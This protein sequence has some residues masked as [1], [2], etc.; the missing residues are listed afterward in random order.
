MIRFFIYA[1]LA[2]FVGLALAGI[3]KDDPGYL[4]ISY[5]A[6]SLETSLAFVLAVLLVLAALVYCLLWVLAR[7]NPLRLLK[8]G[9]GHLL[10]RS[11]RA[12]SLSDKGLLLLTLGEWQQAYALLVE[13]A[14]RV[15]TP[16]INFL[17]ASLA[18]FENGDQHSCR[19]CL[20]QAE[21]NASGFDTNIQSWRARL[22][23]RAGR[24]EQS[25]S[26]LLEL[27]KKLPANKY[28]LRQIKNIYLQLADW[29]HLQNLLPELEKQG[30]LMAEELL[31]LQRQA[32]LFQFARTAP[33]DGQALMSIWEALPKN[34]RSDEQVL[35]AYLK[36]LQALESGH[37]EEVLTRVAKFLRRQWSDQ[38]AAELGRRRMLDGQRQEKLLS[39]WFRDQPGNAV[40]ALSLGRVSMF[41]EDWQQA[42]E[43]FETALAR[44][45]NQ[46]L[47]AGINA[48][49]GRL[50]EQMGQFRE[51]AAHYRKA[52]APAP[53]R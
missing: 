4:L 27:K 43:Y 20:E 13:N 53:V 31:D 51:S 11:N 36:R 38:V 8:R 25:L 34:L 41:N 52:I 1:L 47:S 5:R 18:A 46:D 23:F 16:L 37:E 40:L 9:S 24:F 6:Y 21:K 45:R 19:Y 35:L 50:L 7:I 32:A 12:R 10:R 30:V 14:A 42:R 39:A 3:L 17:A 33:D 26:I 48:E 49:L 2:L 28:I 29:E 22:E 15:E 44:S